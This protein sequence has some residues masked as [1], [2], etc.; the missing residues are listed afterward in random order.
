MGSI[1]P[2]LE[3][4]Q[5]LSK[6]EPNWDSY[7]GD[8]MSPAAIATASL[9]IFVMDD[10]RYRL[11]G[12][13]ALPWTIAPIPNGG[14]LI[15]WKA[16]ARKVQVEI[17]PEGSLSYLIVDRSDLSPTYTEEHDVPMAKIRSLVRSL[18][19]A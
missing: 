14:I 10:E 19:D 2:S 1:A 12:C 16:S 6:L 8:P 13:H 7:D 9:L 17:D 15:E 4:L 3:R 18:F 5:E 11:T